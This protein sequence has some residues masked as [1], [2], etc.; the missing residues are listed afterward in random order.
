M[1]D[2]QSAIATVRHEQ[3]MK[4]LEGIDARLDALNGR[5]RKAE[6][7]IAVL[8]ERSPG[9]QGGIAGAVGGAVAGFLAGLVRG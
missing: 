4:A 3:V 1:A 9:K 2:E 8:Q 6:V 5:T 7:D